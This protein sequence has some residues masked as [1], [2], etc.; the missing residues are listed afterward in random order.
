MGLLTYDENN[1]KVYDVEA[2]KDITVQ[3]DIKLYGTAEKDLEKRK[4]TIIKEVP[5]EYLV[6]EK[7][8]KLD[9]FQTKTPRYV[10]LY[11][12]LVNII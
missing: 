1:K 4:A 10:E 11:N 2:I 5:L 8:G 3:K 7:I 12:Y 9:P 6:S